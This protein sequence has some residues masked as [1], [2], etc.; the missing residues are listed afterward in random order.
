MNKIIINI[1]LTGSLFSLTPVRYPIHEQEEV[2]VNHKPVPSVSVPVVTMDGHILT[3][4]FVNNPSQRDFQIC[5]VTPLRIWAVKEINGTYANMMYQYDDGRREATN[6]FDWATQTWVGDTDGYDTTG[7]RRGGYGAFAVNYANNGYQYHFFVTFHSDNYG[8]QADV[9]WPDTPFNPSNPSP[10]YTVLEGV[11]TMQTYPCIGI[12]Q[13]GYLHQI[14]CNYTS[15]YEVMYNRSR[16]LLSWDGYITLIPTADSPWY[17]LYADP[18]G[19]TLVLTYCRTSSDNHIIMLV[20]TMAGDMFYA[21]TPLRVDI[22]SFIYAKTGTP[23]N[24]GFVGDGL[25]FVDRDGNIHL[26]TFTWDGQNCVP[27]EIYHFFWDLNADTMNVSLIQTLNEFY[28]PIGINTLLAGRSQMG[29]VRETGTLYAIWEEF[30]QEPNRFVVSSTDDTLAPTRIMLAKSFDNGL[31]WYLDTLL[32]SDMIR[33]SNDWLRFPVISPVIPLISSTEAVW[34]GVY[35]DDDPGFVWQG[36]GGV[37]RVSML[38]GRKGPNVQEKRLRIAYGLN[39]KL[40]DDYIEILLN[41]PERTFISIDIFSITGRKIKT[42]FNGIKDRGKHIIR[43]NT[44]SISSNIYFIQAEI[45]NKRKIL[46]WIKIK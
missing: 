24:T 10:D 45:K 3:E 44:S 19:N 2:K 43:W 27:T 20:D 4:A 25:P 35:D 41:I 5:R 28:Y 26:I 36:Q 31:T 29:Q 39:F 34:W 8:Y 1:L 22:D 16:D 12:T 15:N 18:F 7:L 14:F 38:V 37:S 32:E 23:Y 13:N 33:D 21:G 30:I 42:I 17:G 40:K 46:K 11:D 9:Q 6:F